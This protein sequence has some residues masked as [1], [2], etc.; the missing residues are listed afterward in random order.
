ML[1]TFGEH[2]STFF[3]KY[4]APIY[5]KFT[6]YVLVPCDFTSVAQTAFN[7]EIFWND[8]IKE[9]ATCIRD[10]LDSTEEELVK[11]AN[12]FANKSIDLEEIPIKNEG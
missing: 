3:S 11:K 4:Y 7:T 1:R 6:Y 8:R 10:L 5:I 2:C 9:H 12:G